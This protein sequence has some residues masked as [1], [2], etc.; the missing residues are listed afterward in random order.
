MVQ[1]SRM[2]ILCSVSFQRNSALEHVLDI[3]AL[4]TDSASSGSDTTGQCLPC[5][6][7]MYTLCSA[8]KYFCRNVRSM[9]SPLICTSTNASFVMTVCGSCTVLN[10]VLMQLC[11][12]GLSCIAGQTHSIS[13]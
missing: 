7:N 10:T 4:C 8:Y 2:S 1:Y 13:Y 12:T 11:R 9:N 3:S 5:F 6:M